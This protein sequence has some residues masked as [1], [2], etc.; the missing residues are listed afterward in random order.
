[1]FAHLKA[2]CPIDV[3]IPSLR[4]YADELKLLSAEEACQ[5]P[6]EVAGSIDMVGCGKVFFF[7][8]M[9]GNTKCVQNGGSSRTNGS[10]SGISTPEDCAN[11]CVEDETKVSKITGMNFNCAAK[12]CS[13]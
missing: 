9:G 3:Q 11:K 1:M 7:S 8:K 10:F 4:A 12:T 13:W 5:L 2:V 6:A